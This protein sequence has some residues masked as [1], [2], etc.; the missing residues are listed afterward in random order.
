ML[1]C[2]PGATKHPRPRVSPGEAG[3]VVAARAAGG[4]RE[5]VP[6]R[7]AGHQPCLPAPADG[8]SV[9]VGPG[10]RGSA[11]LAGAAPDGRRRPVV[12]L[13]EH[14]HDHPRWARAPGG[15]GVGERAAGGRGHSPR[16]VSARRRTELGP[17]RAPR[18]SQVA[19]SARRGG[20][21]VGV[22]ARGPPPRRRGGRA[23]ARPRRAG[24][25]S[26]PSSPPPRPHERARARGPRVRGGRV[27][28]RAPTVGTAARA[29]SRLEPRARPAGP[30]PNRR[31]RRLGG[32]GAARQGG[33]TAAPHPRPPARRARVVG[34]H[35][36]AALPA[37]R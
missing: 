24:R 30:I 8:R 28:G 16:R 7:T 4:L 33:S 37:R 35:G 36:R 22:G 11:D 12:A 13:N 5:V 18:R 32:R 21:G 10:G 1:P 29:A 15:W 23:G 19:A 3:R 17:G 6:G 14:N 26:L 34:F 2:P 20:G 31:E 27:S 9:G 25:P